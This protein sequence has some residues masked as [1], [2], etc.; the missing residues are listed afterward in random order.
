[1]HDNLRSLT[2]SH[3]FD[4]MQVMVPYKYTEFI[5]DLTSLVKSN[6]VPMDRINDAVERILLVKFTMGLF[7]DPYT[8]LSLVDE[9]GSQVGY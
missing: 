1:M 8:D 3:Q 9:V 4:P 6:I 5:D 2:W 7:E